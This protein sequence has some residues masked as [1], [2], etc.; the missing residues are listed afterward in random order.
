MDD[1]Y[2]YR[3]QCLTIIRHGKKERRKEREK[4]RKVQSV[5]SKVGKRREC[6]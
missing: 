2:M 6:L 5:T 1:A 4:E 3:V